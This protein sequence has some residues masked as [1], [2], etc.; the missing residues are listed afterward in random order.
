MC[1]F[2]ATNLVNVRG[3]PYRRYRKDR[4]QCPA[5]SNCSSPWRG[6]APTDESPRGTRGLL[7][8]SELLHLLQ[9]EV[10]FALGKWTDGWVG[11]RKRPL[12]HPAEPYRSQLDD[13]HR[14]GG[15]RAE[16]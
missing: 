6:V 5:C 14:E 13:S 4:F 11:R 10:V 1:F 2:R 15:D 3:L 9:I 16:H 7:P 12:A 8:R